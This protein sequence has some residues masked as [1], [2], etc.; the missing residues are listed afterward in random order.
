VHQR[1]ENPDIQVDDGCGCNPTDD[2]DGDGTLDCLEACPEDPQ[3]TDEGTCG[4]AGEPDPAAG[5]V[6]C[7]DLACAPGVELVCDAAGSCG[8][9][10]DCVAPAG[11]DAPQVHDGHAYSR[12]ADALGWDDAKAACEA[13][14]YDLARIDDAEE[15]SFIQGLVSAD[16]W[17]AGRGDGG[18]WSWSNGWVYWDGGTDGTG[19]GLYENWRDGEPSGGGDACLVIRSADGEWNDVVNCTDLKDFVC[20]SR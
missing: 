12:C 14:G 20:E 11:C 8:S 15:N 13:A 1:P 2:L 18:Q 4:C 6:S 7:T 5:N 16:S 19:T 9:A 3:R 17:V 10:A